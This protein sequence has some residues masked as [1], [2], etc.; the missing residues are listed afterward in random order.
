M[1]FENHKS[2]LMSTFNSFSGHG[3]EKIFLPPRF[4]E[5]GLPRKAFQSETGQKWE[6]KL[7]I[8]AEI[9]CRCQR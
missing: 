3:V 1:T 4:E 6:G 5:Q 9:R 8:S 7:C 2:K